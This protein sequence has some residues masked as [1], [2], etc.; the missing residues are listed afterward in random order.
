MLL[1]EV[2]QNKDTEDHFPA[3]PSAL[4]IQVSLVQHSSFKEWPWPTLLS[5]KQGNNIQPDQIYYFNSAYSE[6]IG[7]E[8]QTCMAAHLLPTPSLLQLPLSTRYLQGAWPTSTV[9]KRNWGE[10][11]GA[12]LLSGLQSSSLESHQAH[13]CLP[14]LAQHKS[15][16]QVLGK[17]P[18]FESLHTWKL[19]LDWWSQER[20][21]SWLP[22]PDSTAWPSLFNLYPLTWLFSHP[23]GRSGKCTVYSPNAE[24][25]PTVLKITSPP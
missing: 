16:S 23:S 5:T 2:H 13:S 3:P 14:S 6:G 12:L 4:N 22:V 24:E 21:S 8:M 1:H 18:K 17:L 11:S 10:A 25:A 9:Q 7:K 20:Q 15:H 19:L